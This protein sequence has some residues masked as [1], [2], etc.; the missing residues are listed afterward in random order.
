MKLFKNIDE[1]L[2]DNEKIILRILD[3]VDKEK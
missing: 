2:E 1:K 3:K